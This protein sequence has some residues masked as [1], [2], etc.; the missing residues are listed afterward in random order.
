MCFLNFREEQAGAAGDATTRTPEGAT[1]SSE[2]VVQ[3][4]K[5][6]AIPPCPICR[7]TFASLERLQTHASNCGIENDD[8]QPDDPFVFP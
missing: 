7:R 1:A 2:T 8:G 5:Q 4:P 6:E 3:Q